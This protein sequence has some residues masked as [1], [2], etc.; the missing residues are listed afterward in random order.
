MGHPRLELETLI[1]I[2]NDTFGEVTININD[3][4]CDL[5]NEFGLNSLMMVELIVALEEKGIV[6]A[7]EDLLV[8]NFTTINKIL[9]TVNK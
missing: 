7:D 9:Y 8:E 6:I 1:N 2:V 4:D 5:V 3:I